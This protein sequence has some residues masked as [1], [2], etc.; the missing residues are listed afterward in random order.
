VLL[1]SG[2]LVAH[3]RRDICNIQSNFVKTFDHVL[4]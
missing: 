1:C 4:L 2:W 3:C